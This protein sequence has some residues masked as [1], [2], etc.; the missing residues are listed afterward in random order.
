[1]CLSRV[2]TDEEMEEWLADK[3]EIMVLEKWVT[4]RN[5]CYASFF[6]ECSFACVY[7]S[8][9]NEALPKQPN[10]TS[11]GKYWPYYHFWYKAPN[12]IE[13]KY[14]KKIKCIIKKSWITAIGVA[15]RPTII[16]KYSVFPHYP[17]TEA[18]WE[19]VRQEQ[20]LQPQAKEK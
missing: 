20:S 1:M 4:V 14:Q 8:G 5:N 3:P 12:W 19:D 15:L 7:K 18:R 2:F 11:N 6:D 17:E 13:N 16:A 9:L 10:N